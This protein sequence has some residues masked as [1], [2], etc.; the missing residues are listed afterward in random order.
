MDILNRSA[1]ILRPKR[2]YLEWAK[3]DDAEGLAEGVMKSLR[4]QPPVYLLPDWEGPEEQQEILKEFWPAL[5]EAM[6][7]GWARDDRLWPTG[8]T[9]EVFQEWFEL[10]M[11]STVEDI[12]M[13]EAIEYLE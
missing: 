12:Y 1:V 11:Y 4:E 8:R 7:N 9:L 3:L 13:D 6:L 5:F 10:Q 2:P